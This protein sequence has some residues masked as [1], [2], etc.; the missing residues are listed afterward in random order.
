MSRCGSDEGDLSFSC[1]GSLHSLGCV[2]VFKGG[3][4]QEEGGKIK[5]GVG[6]KKEGRKEER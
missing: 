4:V 6:M 1:T 2:C 3:G 5:G